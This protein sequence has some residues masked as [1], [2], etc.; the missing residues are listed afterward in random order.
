[1]VYMFTFCNFSSDII[2]Q[3]LL[4]KHHSYIGYDD[5][6]NNFTFQIGRVKVKVTVGMFI[7]NIF[8]VLALLFINRF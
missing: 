6:L 1:M 4:I 5:G 3:L 2:Y 8:I 7:K